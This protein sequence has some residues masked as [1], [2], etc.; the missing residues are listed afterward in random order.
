MALEVEGVVDGSV[1]AQKALS[2]S[3]RF[4]ALQLVLASSHHLVR[5][6]RPIVRIG[7]A[8]HEGSARRCGDQR[9]IDLRLVAAA[10]DVRS[11]RRGQGGADF[12]TERGAL[13]FEPY[14]IRVN[15]VSPG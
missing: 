14:G 3:G 15:T 7:C 4:K 10:R 1:H 6:L 8:A 2:G 11:I 13:E 5:V 9:R 12:D